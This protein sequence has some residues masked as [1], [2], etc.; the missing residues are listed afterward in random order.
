MQEMVK[1]IETIGCSWKGKDGLWDEKKGLKVTNAIPILKEWKRYTHSR[2]KTNREEITIVFY[3]QSLK[4]SDE[5]IITAQEL[6]TGKFVDKMPSDVS[7]YCGYSKKI[8]EIFRLLIQMQMDNHPAEEVTE[9]DQGWYNKQFH[10]KDG[11]QEGIQDDTDSG[12]EPTMELAKLISVSKCLSGTALASIH[13]LLRRL[14]NNAEIKHNFVTYLEGQTSI[15]KSDVA[16]GLGVYLP[17]M[18]TFLSIGSDKKMLKR[19]IHGMRDGTLIL[20]DYNI[21][22]SVRIRERQLDIVSGIIQNAS[23]S[24]KILIDGMEPCEEDGNIHLMITAEKRID[25][26]STFN[27]CFLL[28]MTEKLPHDVWSKLKVFSE[29]Q[30]M[31]G[32]MRGFV[33]WIEDNYDEIINRMRINYQEYISRARTKLR[34]EEVPGIERIRCTLAVQFT[35]RKILLDYFNYMQIDVDVIRQA[36]RMMNCCIWDGGEE[37]CRYMLE[38]MKK[39]NRLQY[40]P[41]LADMLVN[42]NNG[43]WVAP[44]EKIYYKYLYIEGPDGVCIGTCL[45]NGYLSFEPKRMCELIAKK[46]NVESVSINSLGAELKYY[47]LVYVDC[48]GKLSCRWHSQKRMYHVRVKELIELTN[49]LEGLGADIERRIDAYL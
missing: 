5:I 34:Y 21:S 10:W 17:D 16:K 45:N 33:S 11:E 8:V 7:I 1:I 13:G 9:H 2:R 49:P 30:K 27:R 38:R 15:G 28:P 46:L 32:F 31:Y 20:D 14:L 6:K 26:F 48:E 29:T 39:Q 23:D 35:L 12:Y 44:T 25:N 24:G 37:M 42:I 43:V 19:S 22:D 4:K 41:T 40:L 47:S 18:N 3:Y 36:E